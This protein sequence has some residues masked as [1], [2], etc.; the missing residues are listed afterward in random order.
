M[1]VKQF[2]SEAEIDPAYF[3]KP[4]FVVPDGDAQA[5][6]FAVVREALRKTG[7]Q[8]E[9]PALLKKLAALREEAL[10][11]DKERYRYKLVD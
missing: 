3:E 7:N 11:K 6:A 9:I 2:V 5:E 1:E 10:K 8:S 4:Y